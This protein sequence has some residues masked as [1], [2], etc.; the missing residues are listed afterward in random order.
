MNEG[1]TTL[2]GFVNGIGTVSCN[3]EVKYDPILQ[4]LEETKTFD[5]MLYPES[6]KEYKREKNTLEIDFLCYPEVYYIK[7]EF[8]GSFKTYKDHYTYE[9]IQNQQPQQLVSQESGKC[10]LKIKFDGEISDSKVILRQYKDKECTEATGKELEYT[11]KA[12]YANRENPI[13]VYFKRNDGF[14]TLEGVD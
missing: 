3:I 14:F 5:Y 4:D 13:E 1:Y 8:E 11:I 10:K 9:L 6:S 2:T 7:A 12:M